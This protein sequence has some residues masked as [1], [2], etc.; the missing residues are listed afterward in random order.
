M[1]YILFILLVIVLLLI[2]LYSN[3]TTLRYNFMVK[4]LKIKTY[5]K[6][7]EIII[8]KNLIKIYDK[9]QIILNFFNNDELLRHLFLFNKMPIQFINVFKIILEYLSKIIIFI[10][11][12]LKKI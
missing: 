4:T 12:Y 5:L 9:I 8:C 2:Y 6:N 10:I 1:I 7:N 3:Y 11:N